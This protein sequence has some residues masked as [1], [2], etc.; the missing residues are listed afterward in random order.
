MRSSAK[1][2]FLLVLACL[3]VASCSDRTPQ[4]LPA[5]PLVRDQN[6]VLEDSIPTEYGDLIAVTTTDVYP[7]FAQL[8]FQKEDGSV[9]TVFLDFKRGLMEKHALVI[10]RS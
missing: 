4:A 5:G 9:V 8:W 7:N 6:V 3:A 1:I 2:T 10:P